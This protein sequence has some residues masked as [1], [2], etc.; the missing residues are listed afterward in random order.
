MVN[1]YI[2][3]KHIFS[4]DMEEARRTMLVQ[5]LDNDARERCKSDPSM[6][7]IVRL[8]HE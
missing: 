5:I 6:F 2:N 4:S 8:E 3:G 1:I 7:E